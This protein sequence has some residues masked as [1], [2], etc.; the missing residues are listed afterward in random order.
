MWQICRLQWYERLERSLHLVNYQV[1]GEPGI[2]GCNRR[3]DIYFNGDGHVRMLIHWS[4]PHD[5]FYCVK[6][7]PV[8]LNHEVIFSLIPRPSHRPGFDR[9]QYAKTRTRRV[10]RCD[11]E[12]YAFCFANVW[13][14]SA[15]G[16]NYKIRPLAHSFDGGPLPP[17]VYLGRHCLH[18]CD[19]ILSPRPSPYIFVCCKQSKTGRWEGLGTRLVIKTAKIF[20]N[21]QYYSVSH[22]HTPF[23][24]R[25]K[26]SGNFCCSRLLHRNS[27]TRIVQVLRPHN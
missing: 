27:F 24:K 4:L 3:L 1:L 19:K 5:I 25:G 2:A 6:F 8:G 9:S 15:W 7:F 11:Q 12:W 21:L 10:L 16:R 20:C 17:S 22:G 23:R 13:N 18:S 26:G 14:S